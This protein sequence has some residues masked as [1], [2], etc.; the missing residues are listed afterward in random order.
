MYEER[1]YLIRAKDR[2]HAEWSGQQLGSQHEHSYKN[3]YGE[4]V[5]WKYERLLEC[6]E[7]DE[8]LG[9]GAEIYS[10]YIVSPKGTT[11]NEIV[12]K[13]SRGVNKVIIQTAEYN[14]KMV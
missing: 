6:Y 3:I 8:K 12:E 4:Q 1:H 14:E 7:V 2:D 13:Y 10:R 5:L 9:D 11:P